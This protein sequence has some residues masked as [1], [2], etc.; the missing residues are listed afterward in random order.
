MFSKIR[1]S[2]ALAILVSAGCSKTGAPPAI[3]DATVQKQK[4][5]VELINSPA[6]Q[7]FRENETIDW[8]DAVPGPDEV[9]NE[10]AEKYPLKRNLKAQNQNA[11]MMKKYYEETLIETY[12]K[13]GI[14]IRLGMI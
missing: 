9:E 7:R 14:A 13:A 4:T 8:T 2:L 11:L 1:I 12:K 10:M 5:I 3:A 6:L